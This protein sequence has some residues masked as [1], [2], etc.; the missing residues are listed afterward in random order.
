MDHI[1]Q[2]QHFYLCFIFNH[3]ILRVALDNL[4]QF[5]FAVLFPL[6]QQGDN[7]SYLRQGGS[8]V[9]LT[10]VKNSKYNIFIVYDY[11]G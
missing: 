10:T 2:I 3:K 5:C 4:V 1:S 9:H 8:R 11:S 7:N 6:Q